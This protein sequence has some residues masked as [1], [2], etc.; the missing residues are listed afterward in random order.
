M[1]HDDRFN[2]NIKYI[3]EEIVKKYPYYKINIINRRDYDVGKITSI[4]DIFI[5]IKKAITVYI[6]KNY[7]LATS[8]YVFLNNIF[9]E[10][11]S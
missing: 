4:L 8:K 11:T 2:G 6:I 7:H 3:Y 9:I 1:T 5:L 10:L